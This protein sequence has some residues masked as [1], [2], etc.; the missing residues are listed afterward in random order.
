ML[1]LNWKYWSEVRR[2]LVFAMIF[3]GI[4]NWAQA[5]G[6]ATI[7]IPDQVPI[8]V[9]LD[10]NTTA[11]RASSIALIENEGGKMV[12]HKRVETFKNPRE[13]DQSYGWGLKWTAGMKD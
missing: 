5:N 3:D 4:P 11:E 7:R 6:K 9:R 2:I 10:Q 1:R 8:S 12:I 13:L